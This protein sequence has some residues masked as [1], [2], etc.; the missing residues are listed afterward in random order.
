MRK[1]FVLALAMFGVMSVSEKAHADVL[2]RPEFNSGKPV[3]IVRAGVNFNSAVGDW[4]DKMQESWDKAQ[5]IP[6]VSSGF[7][8][9]TSFDVSVAFNKSFGDRPL[10]WGMELGI[11][12]RGFEANAE[13][14]TG[15]VSS[16]WGDYI[17]HEIKQEQT[18]NAYNANLTPFMIGYKYN[19]LSA[20][21][22][23]VHL[24]GFISYDFAGKYKVYDYDWQTSSN[25]P[26]TTEKTTKTDISDLDKYSCFDAG[27]NLGFGVWYGHFNIDFTWQRGFV[28][29]FDTDASW[30]SQSLKLRVGYAF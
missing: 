22:L 7:P 27:I 15:H 25:R 4:K 13:W 16:N 26:R 14:K 9:K 17:G 8:S 19:L 18:L 30:Q 28:D 12:T 23:D 29:M 3:W 24:G 10:Y 6:M 5:R 2:E 1:F 11:S 20:M 21:T